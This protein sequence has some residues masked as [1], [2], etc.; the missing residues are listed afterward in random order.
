MNKKIYTLVAIL[1]SLLVINVVRAEEI[2]SKDFETN[3]SRNK[4]AE[5]HFEY[6]DG[7]LLLDEDDN[8]EIC[9]LKYYNYKGEL[10]KSDISF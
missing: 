1:L 10:I 4:E 2:Y 9:T 8:T 3:L 7:Y 6:K 5:S